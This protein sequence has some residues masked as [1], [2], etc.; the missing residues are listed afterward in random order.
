VA[1]RDVARCQVLRTGGDGA[2][3]RFGLALGLQGFPESILLNGE[4][5]PRT[6][7]QYIEMHDHSRFLAH[8]GLLQPDEAA[9]PLFL[10]GD[11]SRWYKLQPYLLALLLAKGI[12][13]LWEGQELGEDYTLPGNGLGRVG[14]LRAMNW[15]YF[16]EDAGRRLVELTRSLLATRRNRAKYGGE[17]TITIR[18]RATSRWALWRSAADS[19][20]GRPSSR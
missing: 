16:Y 9:D 3:G 4:T 5:L 10:I 13:M 2:V 15:Q 20:G 18:T 11:R 17:I 19:R 6:A 12:P 7:L 8:F 1:G 14:L